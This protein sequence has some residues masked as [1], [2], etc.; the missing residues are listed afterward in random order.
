MHL[1]DALL[2]MPG[3]DMG[4]AAAWLGKAVIFGIRPEDIYDRAAAH[5]AGAVAELT[6]DIAA[7]EP[8]GAETLVRAVVAGHR[9]AIS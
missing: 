1:A 8:L 6:G 5:P 3:L 4:G 9:A 7:V 2:P